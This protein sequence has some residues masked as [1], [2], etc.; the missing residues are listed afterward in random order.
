VVERPLIIGVV[1]GSGSGKTTVTR[2]IYEL[3]GVDAVF[4]D[5][6][7]VQLEIEKR[8]RSPVNSQRDLP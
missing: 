4:I 6:A 1:G 5:Q 3:P 8:Q 2:A 7:R